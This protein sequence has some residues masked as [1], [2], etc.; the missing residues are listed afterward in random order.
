MN[1]KTILTIA[2]AVI[3]FFVG[4]VF[5]GFLGH[6]FSLCCFP[7]MAV[8]Y[9]GVYSYLD[10][11]SNKENNDNGIFKKLIGGSLITGGA[12]YLGMIIGVVIMVIFIM[13]NLSTFRSSVTA[14]NSWAYFAGGIGGGLICG[15]IYVVLYVLLS[16]G[17]GYLVKKLTEKK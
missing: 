8:I 5:G 16:M 15:L 1:S 12:L 10:K 2:V 6:L 14:N 13:P 3:N 4:L 9:G 17:A 11:D 7:L